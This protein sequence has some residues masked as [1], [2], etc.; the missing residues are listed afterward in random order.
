MPLSFRKKVG[1]NSKMWWQNQENKEK[2]LTRNRK[3]SLSKMGDK[4]PMKRLEVA[5]KVSLYMTERMLSDKNPMY[6]SEARAKVSSKLMGHEVSRDVR[7]K[8]SRNLVGKL[9]GYKNPFWGRHHTKEVKMKSR[10]RAI[11]MITSGLLSS[12]RT[13]IEIKIKKALLESGLIFQEQMPLEEIT[14][15]D[16]YLP[17]YKIVIYCDG[18]YWHKG[19]WAKKHNVIRKDNWQNKILESGGYKVFRFSETDINTSPEKCINLVGRFILNNRYG[20]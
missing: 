1:K 2:I 12:R 15:V 6:N 19:E 17:K 9:V 5:K 18:D 8:I 11:N 4:N 10:I 14:V 3:I 16:F 7:E 13:E 20:K